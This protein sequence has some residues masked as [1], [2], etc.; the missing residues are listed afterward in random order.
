M[1]ITGFNP[2]TE[3]LEKTFI[4]RAVG[5]GVTSLPV[6]N[7]DNFTATAK[8]LAGE[9]GREHSEILT[10]SSVTDTAI[11]LSAGSSFSHSADDPV[12]ELRY[13]KIKFYRSTTGVSGNY[14]EIAEVDIDVDNSDLTTKYDDTTGLSTYHYKISYYNSVTTQESELSDPIAGTG[15]DRGTLGRAIDEFLRE[16]KD[17]EQQFVTRQT[18]IDWANEC[19]DDLLTRTEKPF[20]F[21]YTRLVRAR[22]ASQNYIDYPDGVWKFDRI[23]HEFNDGVT[24]ETYT[25]RYF[26]PE[27]FRTFYS[28]NNANESDQTKHYTLD[29]AV[30]RVRIGPTPKTTDSDAF[31]FYY[32][33]TFTE[34]DSEGDEFETPTPD[35]YKK[36]WR[37]RFYD[38][39]SKTDSSLT[40]QVDRQ[41]ADYEQ[42]IR[43]L[44][45]TNQKDGG[46]PKGF[47]A[48]QTGVTGFRRY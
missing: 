12:Y 6:K 13:D 1:I 38:L 27:K 26:P 43:R 37:W 45:H 20:D 7:T 40:G 3:G 8:I 19:N 41:L 29:D 31:Y 35:I 39:K 25:L 9:M 34:L 33:K 48:P 30:D 46:S 5:A 22:T 23:D 16:V 28:N 24:N 32:W 21:L 42:A 47:G 10:I 18:L 17:E 11:A 4:S 36:Y 15:Y 2:S 44:Q 14:V